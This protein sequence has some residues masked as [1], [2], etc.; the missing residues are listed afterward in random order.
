MNKKPSRSSWPPTIGKDYITYAVVVSDGAERFIFLSFARS[1]N[2]DV[3]V[4]IF[5]NQ[6]DLDWKNWKPH[7][8]YHASCNH[9]QKS[10]N[11]SA[12]VSQRQ[13]ADTGFANI[14]NIVTMLIPVDEPRRLNNLGN[15][16][17]FDYC[18]EIRSRKISLRQT[19]ML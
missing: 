18:F 13:E 15:I 11:R 19:E 2:G 4:N 12:L 9:H 1:A 16:A 6:Q 8:S 17:E 3:H 7:A 5:H 14:E 10:F